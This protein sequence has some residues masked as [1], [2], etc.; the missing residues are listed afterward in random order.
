MTDKTDAAAEAA[1]VQESF[2]AAT[3][4]GDA[5]TLE[6]YQRLFEWAPQVRPMFPDDI[7]G[8]AQVLGK[9]LAFAVNGLKHPEDLAAPL[10]KLGAR[11]AGYGVEPAHY[12][13][14]ADVLIE[15]LQS[16]LK[17]TWT[18]AHEKAWRSA[19]DLVAKVMISGSAD[20]GS[21]SVA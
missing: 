19:L 1:L 7:S 13:V 18:S 17:D 21:A 11:H 3:A 15:T 4:L 20:E 2:A 12:A 16:N 8:Q 9:T 10:Q 14:V 6:F 5:L